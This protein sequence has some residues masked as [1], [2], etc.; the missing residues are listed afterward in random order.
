[1]EKNKQI[2]LGIIYI[3]TGI[4]DEFWKDF[5][6][7]CECYFCPDVI[8]G[9][10]VFTDSVRLQSM[11]LKNVIWHPVKDRGFIR[12][13]SAKSEFICSV[14]K[15]IEEKYDYIFFL[16]GNFKF[17]EPI[18]SEEILPDESN[19]YITA[20][21]FDLNKHK[22]PDELSYDR[23]PDCNAYI[24]K[25]QGKRY[26]Q[27]GLYGGRTQEIIQMS[28]WIKE[29]IDEDLSKKIIAR[30]HDE[31]YVNKYLK[32]RN[33]RVLNETYAFVEEIMPYR[34][35]KNIVLEKKK[36]LGK[37]LDEY[38]DLSID[39]S[40]SFM[41][42]DDLNLHKIGIVKT[43]GRLG[44]Q[45][46]QYAY[47]SYLRKQMKSKMDFYLL[48]NDDILSRSFPSL[49]LFQMS[50]TLKA[51]FKN[52]N[53]RQIEKVVEMEPSS[54]QYIDEPR[55]AITIYSGY[56]QCHNY[57]DE[58]G[59]E[60]KTLFQ[61]QDDNLCNRYKFF[62]KDINTT[63]SVSIHIRRGDYYTKKNK[64]VYGS[65]CNL[66]YYRKA[67]KK[68]KELLS[69]EPIFY[70]FTDEKE[71]VK[72][73]FTLGKYVLIE[74]D[75]HIDEWQDMFL[76]SSCK[77]HII[78][79]SSF[80]WW[81]AWLGNYENKIVIA[82]DRW[83][84]GMST[85]DILPAEWIRIPIKKSLGR[86]KNLAAN[87]LF[88]KIMQNSDMPYWNEMTRIIYHFY[89]AKKTRNSYYREEAYS[90]LGNLLNQLGRVTNIDE[91]IK[92]SCAI[93]FLYNRNYIQGNSNYMFEQ[94]DGL[95][96][97]EI[98]KCKNQRLIKIAEYFTLRLQCKISKKKI[99]MHLEE[100]LEFIFKRL[101]E[102]RRKL[103]RNE[104]DILLK[105][106]DTKQYREPK[107]EFMDELYIYCLR[108]F[109]VSNLMFINQTNETSIFL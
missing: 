63:C 64:D 48:V 11:T 57:A 85:P 32:D 94:L 86:D 80:S 82:P 99:K 43:Q 77:H 56:W 83:Y 7:S 60:L 2:R 34:P 22:T 49:E 25:G 78:A 54:F 90:R 47:L 53:P 36:Y 102:N 96:E 16:N 93:V 106:L 18:Y 59:N 103:N 70:V 67:M 88:Q 100:I 14:A 13:V 92:I 33:P 29:R 58:L 28:E 98:I 8:K 95:F 46:F 51:S 6:P 37:R 71:W 21:S 19:D 41:L 97:S 50:D 73:H 75:E 76:M 101:W 20:L 104:L 35:H 4:Y 38:K 69:E 1:M 74:A 91:L 62:L 44:N 42:D 84:I 26:Y 27:G 105:L 9:Y 23:N 3:A 31:S 72:N 30:W 109:D 55:K 89:L 65:I 39:N 52:V 12:N 17:I 40:V 10:E 66:E 5:Y 24:P 68:V 61:M 15:V 45:M 87:L 107:N 108:Y 79:N 81:G